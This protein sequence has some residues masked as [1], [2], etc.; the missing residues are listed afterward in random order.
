MTITNDHH[1]HT[2]SCQTISM[3]NSLCQLMQRINIPGIA[4]T[5]IINFNGRAA[6]RPHLV[7]WAKSSSQPILGTP[8]SSTGRSAFP[9][10]YHMQASQWAMRAKVAISK[11]NTAAPYSLYRSSFLATLTNLRRRAVFSR[12]IRVV[13]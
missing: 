6:G 5:A 8:V 10:A 12:P 7:C 4:N 9:M 13:V 1:S 3:H 2:V 11:S